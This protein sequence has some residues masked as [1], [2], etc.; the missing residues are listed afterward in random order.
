MYFLLEVVYITN[1]IE[2]W[3]TII[4][5]FILLFI[6]AVALTYRQ[7]MNRLS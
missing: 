1:I 7:L 5:N 6:V 2:P 3:R 4:Q